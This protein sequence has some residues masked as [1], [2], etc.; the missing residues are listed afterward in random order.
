[1][2]MALVRC[3]SFSSGDSAAGVDAETDGDARDA[4]EPDA[5]DAGEAAVDSPPDAAPVNVLSNGDFEQGAGGCKDWF[6]YA[7]D[8]CVPTLSGAADPHSGNRSCQ[9]CFDSSAIDA[10]VYQN[11]PI[12]LAEAGTRFVGS[13]WAKQPSD[14]AGVDAS[15][16]VRVT[17]YLLTPSLAGQPIAKSIN[18]SWIQFNVATTAVGD[19]ADVLQLRVSPNEPGNAC[20]VV[21]DAVVSFAK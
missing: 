10:Y 13:I 19:G 6:A 2:A 17:L 18:A 4:A 14:D 11:V 1:M 21:D 12:P 20:V 16:S 8:G 9:V 3:S 5:F 7:Q 15:T